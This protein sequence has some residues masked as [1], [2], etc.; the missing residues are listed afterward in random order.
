MTLNPCVR[1]VAGSLVLVRVGSKELRPLTGTAM[2]FHEP[3]YAIAGWLET[4][5][6]VPGP[7]ALRATMRGAQGK[8][9]TATLAV[10]VKPVQRMGRTTCR[11]TEVL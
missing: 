8:V 2:H 4:S 7:Y 10:P 11:V 1:I 6:L 5:C 3:S 9:G